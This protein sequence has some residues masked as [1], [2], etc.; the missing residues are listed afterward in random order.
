ME[1]FDIADQYRIPVMLLGD[2]MLGQMME[3]VEFGNYKPRKKVEKPWA[4]TG[5][6][7][8]RK[9]NIINSLYIDPADL[10]R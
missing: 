6:Q 10:E 7:G 2:G 3:P 8:K 5:T 4:S 1:S 9:P